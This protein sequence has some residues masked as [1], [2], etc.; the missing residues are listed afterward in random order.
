MDTVK[1]LSF[2]MSLVSDEIQSIHLGTEFSGRGQR[3]QQ[4]MPA[5]E[6]LT[7]ILSGRS[8]QSHRTR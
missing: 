6:E 5:W 3:V 7:L 8:Q 2:L 4:F 1:S